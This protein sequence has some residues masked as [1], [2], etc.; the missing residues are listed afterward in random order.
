MHKARTFLVCAGLLGLAFLMPRPAAAD[1]PNDPTVN[2]PLCTAVG[3]QYYPTSVSDGEGGAIVTW[4]D[5][6]NGYLNADIYAQRISADGT[7]KWDSNGVALC[8]ATGYQERPAIAPDGVGGAIVTWAD[9]RS[10][11]ATIYAR[12]ISADGTPLWAADGVP[13]CTATGS[14]AL[15]PIIASDGAGGAIVAWMD[16]RL[17]G[18]VLYAQRVDSAGTVKWPADGVALCTTPGAWGPFSYLTWPT[19]TS[20]DAGGAIVTWFDYRSGDYEIYAQKISSGGT[21]QWTADG[22]ALCTAT[23]SFLNPNS[24]SNPLGG[25]T[26]TSDG[27]GGAIV[28]WQDSRSG[29]NYDIYAQRI[30]PTG[31]PRWTVDGVALCAAD[32]SQAVPQITSDGAGGA[33]VTWHDLRRGYPNLDIYAQRVDSAGTVQWDNDGVALCTGGSPGQPAIVSDGVGGAIVTWA[34]LRF[35]PIHFGISAQRISSTGTVQW[36]NNG[37]AISSALPAMWPTI[38]SDGA[39]G[40]IVAWMDMR[41]GTHFDIYAQRVWTDGST[42]VLLSLVSADLTADGV[43]LA[44]L[45][46]GSGSSMATVYRSFGAGAWTRIGEVAADGTGYLR[47]TDPIDAT[48]TRVGY[49]LGIIE[50]GIEGFYGETWVDLPTGGVPFAFA[51]DPVRPNPSRGGALTV[52]FSLPTAAPARLDLLDVAGRRIASHEVGAG[53]HTLD[54]GGGQHLAPGLYLVRL[55]QG[56]NTRTTRVAVLR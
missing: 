34:E 46:G 9:S 48:A 22:V 49:R 27:A 5:H 47:Y 15:F 50:A 43:K 41:G 16:T 36:T 25:P 4:W 56:T 39:D 35:D 19:I 45:A 30:S 54:L 32:S 24:A 38:V 7:V 21:V 40:A 20:D 23:G 12:R 18:G 14:Q 2:V 31:M 52:R 28:T 17:Q 44:W 53:Q 11:C 10:G 1:W 51:L 33:I 26:I 8:T 6:R 29:I 13:L 37:V 3:D 55:T 42:P